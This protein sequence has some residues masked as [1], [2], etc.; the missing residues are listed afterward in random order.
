MGVAAAAP[1]E[2]RQLTHAPHGHLLTNVAVWSPDGAWIYYDVRSDPAGTVFD[3]LT[4]ERVHAASGRVETVYRSE[5]GACC[6]AVTASPCDDRVAFILGPVDPAPD[7]QY[8]PWHRQGIVMDGAGRGP[9][10]TLDARDV[11]S[12]FTPGALRGGTHVHV[13]SGDARCISFT[14]ED[15]VLA[16]GGDSA[17]QANQRNVGVA[18]LGRPVLTPRT[19]PRNHDGIAFCAVV[20]RTVDRPTPGS[21]EISR[22]Y[23]DAWV[24]ADGYLRADGS[25]Q[26]R[27]LAF[28][29]DATTEQGRAI[30]ELY[31]VDL[32][33]G[34]PEPGS[35]PLE[36]TPTT[37]PAPPAGTMQRRLTRTA[38]RRYPGLAAPRHWPRSSPDGSRIAFL[39]RDDDGVTQLWTIAPTG[40]TPRQATRSPLPI[41]SAFSWSPD[42]THVAC[43]VDDSVCEAD[44][45]TGTVHRV[46]AADRDCPPRPEACVY[47]PDGSQIAFVRRLPAP[48]GTFNQVCVV[49]SQR[50]AAKSAAAPP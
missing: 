12:P 25:R 49:A 32:P 15:H 7:W 50:G 40:G 4:I 42:G 14:Y 39:M 5:R 47:S 28:I 21:D 33:D 13:F 48:Q 30:P 6:G 22:A 1:V 24:G 44:L 11:V 2:P 8:A 43:V 19:H 27:A 34:W 31:V 29:G 37:R 26:H 3:G 36:G 41:A 38:G 20:T 16:V 23:E 17:A 35:A 9:A 46:A 18:W 10:Q 45:E